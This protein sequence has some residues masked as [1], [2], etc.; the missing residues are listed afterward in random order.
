[1]RSTQCSRGLFVAVMGFFLPAIALSQ[2]PHEDT[3]FTAATPR[4]DPDVIVVRSSSSNIN[5]KSR[6][7]GTWKLCDKEVFTP[8]G[9]MALT[10]SLVLMY[11]MASAR[12]SRSS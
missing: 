9:A 7:A 5:S 4:P 2:T 10:R 6:S 11:S 1:M 3:G 8:P 12:A